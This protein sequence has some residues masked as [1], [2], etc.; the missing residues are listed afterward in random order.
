MRL[1]SG[2]TASY[3]I[4]DLGSTN[5]IE[6]KGERIEGKKIEEGDTF[7]IC[8]YQFEVHVQVGVDACAEHGRRAHTVALRPAR[9]RF[10]GG[11]AGN[12]SALG[13]AGAGKRPRPAGLPAARVR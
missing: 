1:W 10:A 13:R 4:K 8:D 11:R 6:Y 7:S 2:A 3:F 5:G 9:D 12:G